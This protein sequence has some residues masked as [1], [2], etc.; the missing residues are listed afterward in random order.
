MSAFLQQPAAEQ[1]GGVSPQGAWAPCFVDPWRGVAHFD[2]LTIEADPITSA[3]ADRVLPCIADEQVFFCRML[4]HQLAGQDLQTRNEMRAL[5]FGTGSG[6][7][8]IAA[9]ALGLQVDAIDVCDRAM[10]FAELNRDRNAAAISRSLGRLSLRKAD[11]LTDGA[12]PADWAAHFDYIF[13]NPPFALVPNGYKVPKSV[14]GGADGQDFLIRAID[15]CETLLK[16]GGKLFAVHLLHLDEEGRL[17][18]LR[19]FL[20]GRSGWV[21]VEVFPAL[22]PPSYSI[23]AFRAAVCGSKNRDVTESETESA[24]TG[25]N[26]SVCL[27]FIA[28]T[29]RDNEIHG[30]T[31]TI[32]IQQHSAA[33]ASPPVT[34]EDRISLHRAVL[35]ASDQRGV[36]PSR[37]KASTATAQDINAQ[38]KS[39]VPAGQV[40]LTRTTPYLGAPTP[41]DGSVESHLFNWILENDLMRPSSD[42][43]LGAQSPPFDVLMIEAAPWYLTRVYEDPRTNLSLNSATS[44]FCTNHGQDSQE[45][46]QPAIA[47][48]QILKQIKKLN[49]M[50]RSIFRHRDQVLTNSGHWNAA[51]TQSVRIQLGDI[52]ASEL[53]D[54]LMQDA[55][56]APPIKP[57]SRVLGLYPSLGYTTVKQALRSLGVPEENPS[58]ESF[59]HCLTKALHDFSRIIAEGGLLPQ[60]AT[61]LTCYLLA[62]PIPST[63]REDPAR[64]E[65]NKGKLTGMVYAYAWSSKPWSPESEALVGDLARIAALMYEEQFA[66]AAE[67]ALEQLSMTRGYM[68]SLSQAQHELKYVVNAIRHAMPESAALA[69]RA[70]FG[71]IL[72][73][74]DATSLLVS[75]QSC[76]TPGQLIRRI[77]EVWPIRFV[78]QRLAS[79]SY[80]QDKLGSLLNTWEEQARQ[81]WADESDMRVVPSEELLFPARTAIDKDAEKSFSLAVLAGISNATKHAQA[82]ESRVLKCDK[83][84]PRLRI[85]CRVST[86]TESALVIASSYDFQTQVAEDL[87]V[88]FRA[89]MN[90]KA[91]Q[92][93]GTPAVIDFHVRKYFRRKT[94]EDV[95]RIRSVSAKEDD[96]VTLTWECWIHF[97]ERA[98][99]A[100]S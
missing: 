44:I 42:N 65:V 37:E 29:R 63:L 51:V 73:T 88:G 86:G 26:G 100:N 13:L 25:S 32:G 17:N 81:Y 45:P 69:L 23:A 66:N 75:L 14:D 34:W 91:K 47:L 35:S 80:S 84:L 21:N 61:A 96:Q 98:I 55:I 57:E 11:G 2:G 10:L 6:V 76:K 58:E 89:N 90:A 28:A 87:L 20:A 39:L 49:R 16:P 31:P 64:K 7:L 48:S 92:K 27:A 46:S 15:R 53:A 52:Q 62:I 38:S 12:V 99:D 40:Y 71:A 70:Y 24:A 18:R 9:A 85:H 95:F 59:D 41:S 33:P 5:D 72:Q 8:G 43:L 74:E 30:V 22:K 36:S 56:D 82:L 97:P 77:K 19:E 54:H 68:D 78:V 3:R 83:G 1:T 50:K 4:A 94:S 93:V 60:G 79:T 67:D